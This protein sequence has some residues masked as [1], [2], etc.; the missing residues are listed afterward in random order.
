MCKTILRADASFPPERSSRMRKVLKGSKSDK[1][2]TWRFFCVEAA[3][4]RERYREGRK[5]RSTWCFVV[6][7]IGRECIKINCAYRARD[8]SDRGLTGSFAATK[9]QA[10]PFD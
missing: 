10:I 3:G 7:S 6:V 8:Q 5:K 4:Q 9:L 1:E 2:G